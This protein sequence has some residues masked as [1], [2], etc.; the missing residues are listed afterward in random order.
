MDLPCNENMFINF[1]HQQLSK[2]PYILRTICHN[3]GLVI[4]AKAKASKAISAEP[5]PRPD[6]HKANAN[7][8]GLNVKAKA[9]DS[10]PW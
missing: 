8:N 10:H 7:K 5:R 3:F 4:Y 9:K 6:I 2:L 1:T